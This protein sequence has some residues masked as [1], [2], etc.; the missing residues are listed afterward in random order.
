MSGRLRGGKREVCQP[1]CATSLKTDCSDYLINIFQL[2]Q[3]QLNFRFFRNIINYSVTETM[4]SSK[5][6]FS[7]DRYHRR[8][9]KSRS[10][11]RGLDR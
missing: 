10:Q 1:M 11:D 5:G 7:S 3:N 8:R 6:S 9:P 4:P 2:N